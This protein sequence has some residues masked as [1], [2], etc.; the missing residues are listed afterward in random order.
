ML[1]GQLFKNEGLINDDQL[2][3]V[4]SEQ[5]NSNERIGSI[6]LKLGFIN[7]QDILKTLSKQFNHKIINLSKQRIDHTL[8]KKI[9]AKFAYRYKIVPIRFEDNTLIVATTDTLNLHVFDDLHLMLEC[10][11]K[12][13]FVT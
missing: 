12:P 11:V 2:N 9:P 7:E 8:I 5:K 4:L 13:V 10:E 1:F 3:K 6:L